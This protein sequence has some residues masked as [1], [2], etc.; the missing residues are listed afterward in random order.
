MRWGCW[1]A[2]VLVL[3][4]IGAA[5]AEDYVFE[6]SVI[7]GVGYRSH[8]IFGQTATGLAGQKFVERISGTG[9]FY[10]ATR[11]EQDAHRGF[12]NYTKEA[13]FEYFPVT[14]E[15]HNY[16][17][18]WTDRVC[19]RNYDAGTI[20]TEAYRNAEH[21]QRGS[22]IVTVGNGTQ[23]FI[24]AR[25]N[26]NVIGKAVVGWSSKDTTPDCKGRYFQIGM[27]REEMTGIFNIEKYVRLSSNC[28]HE[29]YVDWMPCA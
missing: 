4:I 5:S 29:T 11:Y 28:S 9:S 14:Y 2:V 3:V 27:S 12:I 25:L 8:E 18:K 19:V 10:D 20:F 26:S 22:E 15:N 7:K 6:S 13:E 23:K 1:S 17:Q 24:E 21:L 16:D